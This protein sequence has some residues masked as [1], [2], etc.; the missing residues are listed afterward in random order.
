MASGRE[1]CYI[2][3][4]GIILCYFISLVILAKPSPIICT[5]IR[6]GLNLGKTR[7]KFQS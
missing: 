6:I 2:L 5:V 3:L 7:H 1:L 4:F